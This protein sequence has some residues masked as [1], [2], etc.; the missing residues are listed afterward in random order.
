MVQTWILMQEF[1]IVSWY[2]HRATEIP[3]TEEQRTSYTQHSV[4]DLA[5]F[6]LILTSSG[7]TLTQP[8]QRRLWACVYLMSC[9]AALKHKWQAAHYHNELPPPTKCSWVAIS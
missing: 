1:Y 4:E 6:K 3:W 2:Y 8:Q 5:E 7:L 9:L